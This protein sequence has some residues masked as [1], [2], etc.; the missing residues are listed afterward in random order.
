MIATG[1]SLL[2][3][4]QI[5]GIEDV[6]PEDA[7]VDATQ[8][9]VAPEAAPDVVDAGGND[10]S[11]ASDASD[12]TTPICT[13]NTTRACGTTGT[14]TCGPAGLWCNC[15]GDAPATCT[16]DGGSSGCRGDGCLVCQEVVGTYACYFKNHPGCA[17]N[18]TCAGVTSGLCNARCPAP[19][20]E[21]ACNCVAAADG[22]W[23][24]C[25]ATACT[26]CTDQTQNY[27][28]Y[29]INHASC[30]KDN[31]CSGSRSKCSRYC[32]QPTPEDHGLL[33]DGGLAP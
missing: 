7:S 9:D 19:T 11:V 15:I 33:D 13:P 20:A 29:F 31:N 6:T 1:A 25:S 24:E 26:V 18:T 12:A 2:G 10:T 4:A 27:S 28:C 23:S 30:L 22:G 32:P 21:D 17:L 5:L 16:G 8:A 14:Q 3:C